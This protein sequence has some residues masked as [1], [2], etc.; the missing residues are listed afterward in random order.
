MKKKVK[1]SPT[2]SEVNAVIANILHYS[3]DGVDYD[4]KR[5]TR[6]EQLIIGNQEML[7]KIKARVNRKLKTVEKTKNKHKK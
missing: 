1:K 5:L 2:V 7:D 4:F 6:S 3:L